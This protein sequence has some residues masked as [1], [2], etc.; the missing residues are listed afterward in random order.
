MTYDQTMAFSNYP[1]CS[2]KDLKVKWKT[3]NTFSDFPNN[4]NHIGF[5][6]QNGNFT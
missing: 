4:E 1:L 6:F 3:D 2:F 5:H